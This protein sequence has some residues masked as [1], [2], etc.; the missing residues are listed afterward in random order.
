LVLD[1]EDFELLSRLEAGESVFRPTGDTPEDQVAFHRL[2][3]R[4]LQLRDRGLVRLPT[5]RVGT[6]REGRVIVVGPCDL[7]EAGSRTLARDRE[8]GPRPPPK[9]KD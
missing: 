3:A 8:L 9:R 2:V 6:N 1:Q 7:T 5:G 4:L